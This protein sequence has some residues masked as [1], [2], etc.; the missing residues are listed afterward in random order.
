MYKHSGVLI[1]RNI[2]YRS[3][4]CNIG[5]TIGECLDGARRKR[6]H[7]SLSVAAQAFMCCWGNHS[8]PDPVVLRAIWAERVCT[9]FAAIYGRV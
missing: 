4:F 3:L 1:C 7:N 5:W 2:N 6:R 9:V 8:P